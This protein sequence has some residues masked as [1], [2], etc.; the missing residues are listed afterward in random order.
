[1]KK[2]GYCA[3]FQMLCFCRGKSF[4]EKTTVIIADKQLLYIKGGHFMKS[5]YY[6]WMAGV[7]ARLSRVFIN[8]MVKFYEKAK[9]SLGI[10]VGEELYTELEKL[11]NIDI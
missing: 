1:M 4:A 10:P 8:R 5:F 11:N 6:T 9:H 2:R 3:E 7:Y